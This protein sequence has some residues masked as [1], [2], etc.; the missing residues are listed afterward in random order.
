MTTAR[1]VCLLLLLSLAA[2]SQSGRT[3]DEL[4]SFIK[5]AIQAKFDDKKIADEVLKIKLAN[6]LDPATIEQVQHMGA[7]QKTIAALHKLAE[8]SAGL[9]AAA[10]P[11][12][13]ASAPIPPPDP[14]ELQQIL[15]AIRE[16]A[17][18]YTQSLPN[19]ICT[20]LTKRHVDPTGTESWRVADTITEQLSYV[21]QKEIYKV[22]MVN[23]HLVA[24]NVGHD[25][26][27]GAS[28][29][30][31]FASILRTIFDPGTQTEFGWER[32]TTWGGKRT[33]V[34]HFRVG[35]PRY[36]IH[37][38]GSKRTIDTGFHGLIFANRD[39]KMVMRVTMECDGIPADFPIQSV[40]LELNYDTIEIS[41]QPFVLPLLSEIHS[42]EGRLLSW[43]EVS[44]HNYHKYSADASISFE[45]PDTVPADKLKEQPPQPDKPP[46]KKK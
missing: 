35:Q 45:T 6:R 14:A 9:P 8:T 21:D 33:Y 26:L 11:P 10:A 7:G 46:A 20:Q 16:N 41:G 5:S 3:V 17:L 32:W 2:P 42:R 28:S 13:A 18:N 38:D 27:G 24:N 43:N 19:Y 30:G 31:E 44:Y 29:S 25:Q 40:A 34:F 4:V 22:V 37:H 23:D 36:S 15:A 39:T 1:S 12:K